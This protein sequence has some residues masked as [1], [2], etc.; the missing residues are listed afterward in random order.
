MTQPIPARTLI[1]LCTYNEF[2][3]LSRLVPEI[4]EHV[5]DAHILVI[6]DNSPDGTG[7]LADELAAGDSRIL[8]LHRPQKEGLGVATVAGFRYGIKHNYTRLINMDADFSHPPR[9]LPAL[10]AQADDFDV[11]IGSR[12]VPGGEV[13]GWGWGRHLMSRSINLYARLLLGL[14]TKDNSGSYRCYRV[15]KLQETPLHNIRARGY[16]IQEEILYLCRRAGCSF[17]EV[18]IRFEERRF[19]SSKINW[20][21]AFSALWVLFRLRFSFK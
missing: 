1:T 4:L 19:G 8:V 16:A 14:K 3:N 9:F 2:E 12:Y 10:L 13:E 11:V 20:K 5:P 18:P 7:Q 21:E 15:S 6:D 17:T